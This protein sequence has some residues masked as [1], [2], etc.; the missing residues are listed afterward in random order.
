MSR[1]MAEI[2]RVK[3]TRKFPCDLMRDWRRAVSSIGHSEG[4][5]ERGGLAPEE[6][7]VLGE[8]ERPRRHPM[9]GQV[10]PPGLGILEKAM[11]RVK[12]ER[13]ILIPI[14]EKT[15]GHRTHSVAELWQADLAEL[16]NE[17]GA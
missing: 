1:N 13:H 10:N 9:D 12:R 7:G 16:L 8:E 6:V 14:S 4:Q 5:Y 2:G 15:C 11:R 3:K 17:A